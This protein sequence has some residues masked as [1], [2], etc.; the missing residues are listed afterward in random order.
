MDRGVR[1]RDRL[2]VLV[3]FALVARFIDV[4]ALALHDVHRDF[5]LELGLSIAL[6]EFTE[7]RDLVLDG[8]RL[9]I[10]K[11]DENIFAHASDLANRLVGAKK[12]VRL[13]YLIKKSCDPEHLDLQ[14]EK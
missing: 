5:L 11:R 3:V 2:G 1:V 12:F 14:H 8:I 7:S 13:G 10:I 6:E 9:T 4:R